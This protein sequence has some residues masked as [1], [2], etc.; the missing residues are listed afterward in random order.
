MADKWSLLVLVTIYE[1]F[2]IVSLPCPAEKSY[3]AA[4][5]G[6]CRPARVN[7]PGTPGNSVSLPN[8]C[9]WET[10]VWFPPGRCPVLVHNCRKVGYAKPCHI[11]KHKEACVEA[12]FPVS[13]FF[14]FVPW[15]WQSWHTPFLLTEWYLLSVA[16]PS[17]LL[18]CLHLHS[19]GWGV[20]GIE[21]I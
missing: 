21:F 16:V 15:F 1:S 18:Y 5:V 13:V 19:P 17:I 11:F 4:L 2:T 8:T 14:T 6:I 9:K 3:R 7:P 10:Q 12:S 20:K